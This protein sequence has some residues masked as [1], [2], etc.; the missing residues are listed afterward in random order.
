MNR[1]EINR[2]VT[3]MEMCATSV[4]HGNVSPKDVAEDIHLW[5]TQLQMM[6]DDLRCG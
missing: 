4:E 6:E 1:E 3:H 5:A 2:I